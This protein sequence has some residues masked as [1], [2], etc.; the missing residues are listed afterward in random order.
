MAILTPRFRYLP[1]AWRSH[2]LTPMVLTF[3]VHYSLCFQ[4]SLAKE[5]GQVL[6]ETLAVQWKS[7][8]QMQIPGHNLLISLDSLHTIS[9]NQ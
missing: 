6:A 7:H 5:S 8:T 3:Q 1:V 4:C 2:P 9:F